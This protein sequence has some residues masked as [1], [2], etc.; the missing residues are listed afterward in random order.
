MCS[1]SWRKI[2]QFGHTPL[3]KI[4]KGIETMKTNTQTS[5]GI[6]K[7]V[8][9]AAAICGTALLLATASAQAASPLSPFCTTWPAVA[10]TPYNE[11]IQNDQ[12]KMTH[13][14]V[15]HNDGK[16]GSILL[17]GPV[18]GSWNSLDYSSFSV[19]LKDP[20]GT[21]STAEVSANLRFVDNNGGIHI[22]ANISSN[23]WSDLSR[24][25]YG[26]GV[27]KIFKHLPSSAFD[28]E[29]GMYMVRIY[30]SRSNTHVLPSVLYYQLCGEV[31]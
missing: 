4:D 30:V 16:T 1:Q 19:F 7:T 10:M 14:R 22:I 18:A 3:T 15:Y 25:S 8:R 2:H 6:A 20:D 17:Y 21:A 9:S 11:S 27:R 12:Y 5:S 24:K 26:N 23:N 29:D 13:E 31:T 28:R